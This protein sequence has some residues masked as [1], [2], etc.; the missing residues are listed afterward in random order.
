MVQAEGKGGEV[1]KSNLLHHPCCHGVPAHTT[2]PTSHSYVL[3]RTEATA[4]VTPDNVSSTVSELVIAA[5][6]K[7]AWTCPMKSAAIG[8]NTTAPRS[9]PIS[10][11]VFQLEC[12]TLQN[13][14]I[15]YDP[16]K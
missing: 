11:S 16:F 12:P 1:S 14:G 7:H 2:S 10:Y 15:T 3:T 6:L 13:P 9:V 5:S 4:P 8:G